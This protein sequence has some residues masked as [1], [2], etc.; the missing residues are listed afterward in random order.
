MRAKTGFPF[1]R[2]PCETPRALDST[3]DTH[4]DAQAHSNKPVP[5]RPYLFVALECD[6]P[7]AGGARYALDGVNHV[8]IGRGARREALGGVAARAVLRITIPGRSVSSR[9][10]D[11]RLVDGAWLLEDQGSTNGTF[12]NG[13]KIES[14]ELEDGDLVEIGHCFFV[15][16]LAVPTPA[17]SET[18]HDPALVHHADPFA[19]LLPWLDAAFRRT[20]AAA[21]TPLTVLVAGQTGTGKELV[22]RAVHALSGRQGELVAVNCAALAPTLVESLLF[23][24]VKGA[25]SGAARDEPGFIR[26]AHRGTLLLDEIAELP[27]NVQAML[28]RAIQEREVVP[29]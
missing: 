28:L 1:A 4:E 27:M 15:L 9:H 29:V 12:V 25:F 17:R 10:A 7:T 19:T 14:C 5:V 21:V 8:K 2:C 16:S 18:E 20:Q 24:H 23:G 22:A 6:R 26:T 3:L 11:M 13:H